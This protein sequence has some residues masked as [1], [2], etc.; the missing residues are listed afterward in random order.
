MNNQ[1]H[2]T[3]FAILREQRGLAAEEL[4][5]SAATARELF[6]ELTGRHRFTLPMERL[7]IAINGEFASWDTALQSGQKLALIPPVAGG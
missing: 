6:S 7:R 4:S 3:Y 2:V 5:T 1:I